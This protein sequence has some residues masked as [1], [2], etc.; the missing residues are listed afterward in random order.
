MIQLFADISLTILCLS[1]LAIFGW[2]FFGK[3]LAP[4]PKGVHVVIYGEGDGDNLEQSIRAII[5]IQGMGLLACPVVIM[6]EGL[7]ASG[8]ILASHLVERW[9]TVTLISSVIGTEEEPVQ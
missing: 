4:I 1:I 6:G 7:S 5:W 3:M 9:P 2:W 8:H